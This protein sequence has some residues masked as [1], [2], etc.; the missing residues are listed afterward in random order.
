MQQQNSSASLVSSSQR[1]VPLRRRPDLVVEL[2]P[3]Q[4]VAYPV[5][6]DPAGLKY[7]RLQPEQYVVL[8][9]LDG[10]RSLQ[11]LRDLVQSQFP[12][13]HVTT[14]EI[15]TLLTGLYEKGVVLSE[16]F[17]QGE[18]MLKR[19]R[20]STFNDW[21]Q[22]LLNPLFIRF[23]G[24]DPDRVL[25]KI[26]PWCGW[27][28]STSGLI[29][30]LLL[31]GCTWLF[32][33]IRFDEVRQRLPEFQQFFGWPNLIY[34]WI[35][36]ALTKVLHEFGHGLACKRFGGEC[37][38]MGLVLM[39]FSPT[40]YC[41]VTDSWMMKNKWQRILIG[42]AGMYFEMILAAMAIIVWFQTRPG[43]LHHVTLNVFFVSTVT[44]VIFNA[45]PLL[46][47]DGYYILSD[48][49]EIPNLQEK[50]RSLLSQAFAWT[51]L[52][53]ERPQDPFMPT[54]GR[55]WFI[56]FLIAST[57]YRWFVMFGVTL[58][59]YTV[60]K[61]YRLQ[62]LGIMAAV[63]SLAG[64]VVGLFWNLFSLLITPRSDPISC[65]KSLLMMLLLSGGIGLFLLVPVPWYEQAACYVEPVGVQHVYSFL[66]GTLEEVAVVPDQD[67]QSGQLLV[68]MESTPLVDQRDELRQKVA[69]QQ[70]E[71]KFFQELKDPEGLHLAREHLRSLT[72]QLVDVELQLRN[73]QL[74]APIA[75]RVMAPPRVA[76][77]HRETV[78]IR[79]PR[80]H[81]TPLDSRNLGLNLEPGTHL[82]SIA[83]HPE[84]QAVLLIRQIDRRDLHV[85]DRV[86]IKLESLP[87]QI[88]SG[89]VKSFSNRQLE[90]P[91]ANLSSKSR[92]PLT[93]VT[94]AEGKEKLSEPVYQALIELDHPPE[95]LVS[96][97]RGSV[98]FVVARRSLFD[99][100]WREF[101]Q[102]FHF[103]L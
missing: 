50:S 76:V 80:W 87:D 41:D 16:R 13:T 67:V 94:D 32:V 19:H 29:S 65:F 63:F 38:S 17:G 102:V 62:S 9:H 96:G 55:G 6:K 100:L 24:W 11:D 66:S 81:G 21:K 3:Y 98:R 35:M 51:V 86:R 18:T 75:G 10:K 95:R 30:S 70:V 52:G 36:L 99:W 103:R 54:N 89:T 82:C 7:F 69:V 43:L 61:P 20:E 44:T 45:N 60:L 34:L 78:A 68:R 79:L 56:A 64:I 49:L 83:P 48:F 25:E 97:M 57:I 14:A 58:F 47:Y 88:L 15:Q 22:T 53:I 59:L 1:P 37:H 40:L 2:I 73:R 77:P 5:I 23:S 85:E 4:N 92:G 26:V 72:K 27:V 12:A 74:T 46:R 93:T 28:F 39:V 31:I 91:P 84:F 90:S 42:A 8:E 71:L 101:R 33:A